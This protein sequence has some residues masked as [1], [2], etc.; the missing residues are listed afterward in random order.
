[1]NILELSQK[2]KKLRELN[3]LTQ[4]EMAHQ[5]NIST[6]AY[7][8]IEQGRRKDLGVN[9]LEKIAQIFNMALSQLIEIEKYTVSINNNNNK[10][11]IQYNSNYY[12][13]GGNSFEVRELTLR[14]EHKD[15]IIKRQEQELLILR[16][17]LTTMQGIIK[18]LKNK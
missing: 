17:E 5:L 1:M 14:L 4:E 15:D 18:I 10:D 12:G 9:E 3:Q 7:A 2:V 6:S 8:Q 11:G 16:Q 13:V